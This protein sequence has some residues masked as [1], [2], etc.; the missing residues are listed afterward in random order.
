[1]F[2]SYKI[3]VGGKTGTAQ[4]SSGSA[5]ALFIGFAPFDNPQIAVAAIIEHGYSSAYSATIVRDIFEQY[6]VS[7]YVED[8][9]IAKNEFLF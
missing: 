5:N 4:V 1:M 8:E 2:R 3:T 7:D 9:I 6:L